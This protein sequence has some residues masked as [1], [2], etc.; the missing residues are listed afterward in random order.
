MFKLIIRELPSC[1]FF[2]LLSFHVS[3]A[4]ICLFIGKA[5][6]SRFDL[7]F[8]QVNF[9]NNFW[10]LCSWDERFRGIAQ[11]EYRDE[12]TSISI[13][14]FVWFGIW[15]NHNHRTSHQL[16]RWLDFILNSVKAVISIWKYFQKLLCSLRLESTFGF[17]WS[18]LNLSA[19][20]FFYSIPCEFVWWRSC[21]LRKWFGTKIHFHDEFLRRHL[22]GFSLWIFFELSSR[23]VLVCD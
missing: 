8:L 3:S 18:L 1:F 20:F 13:F 11:I 4:L 17:P 21:S 5:T 14:W 16:K 2:I 6:H 19:C 12:I 10:L 9:H 22:I 15:L 23:Q 7:F